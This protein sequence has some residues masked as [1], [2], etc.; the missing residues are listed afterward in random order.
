MRC[1]VWIAGGDAMS[2]KKYSSRKWLN[3][4]GDPSTGSICCYH[5]A[6]SWNKKTTDSYLEVSDCHNSIRLHKT[7]TQS[8]HD[9]LMKMKK[10]RK[11]IDDFIEFLEE[12]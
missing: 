11:S 5:G 4:K 1:C 3:K 10:I 6:S 9:F 12:K 7:K 2:K 8:D